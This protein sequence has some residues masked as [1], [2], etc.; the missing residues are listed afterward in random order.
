MIAALMKAAERAAE[1]SRTAGRHVGLEVRT[2]GVL[3]RAEYRTS[4][5]AETAAATKLVGWS[6]L[7][8][9]NFPDTLLQWAVEEVTAS[10]MRLANETLNT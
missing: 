2:D 8:G 3:V 5:M 10:V 4:D 7:D 9:A 1:L 6:Q